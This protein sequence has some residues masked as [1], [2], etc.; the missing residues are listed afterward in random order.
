MFIINPTTAG[1]GVHSV[2]TVTDPTDVNSSLMAPLKPH[3]IVLFGATGDLAKRKLLPGL[4]HLHRAGLMPECRIVGSSLDD[5][6]TDGFRNLAKEACADFASRS[7]TPDEWAAFAARLSFVHIGKGPDAL[8]A[9][10]SKAEISL[11]G[12]V[13]RRLHY[14]SVPPNAAMSVVQLLSDANLVD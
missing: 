14:V 3:V 9:A 7:V 2:A 13:V 10:V 4:L 12:D 6:D 11:G 5:L 1:H 8:A